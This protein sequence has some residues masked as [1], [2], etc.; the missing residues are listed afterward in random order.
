MPNFGEEKQAKL[1]N[2]KVLV[3][4]TGGLGS[5]VDLYLAAA[6]V[7]TLG[8]VDPDV[9]DIT[10]LQRQILHSTDDIDRVKVDSAEET[11]K[12]LNPNTKIVKHNERV[13]SSNVLK[14]IEYYDVVVDCTDNFPARFL[15]NDACYISKKP[16]VNGTIY[17]FDGQAITIIPG[18]TACYRCVYP[19]PP[20]ASKNPDTSQLGLIGSV[21]GVIGSILATEVIKVI[22]GIGNPL[23]NRL[24]VFDALNLDFKTYKR[25][26]DEN[27]PVCGN[28]PKI[29]ELIDYEKTNNADL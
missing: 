14:L 2:A 19:E 3:I 29:N 6:G 5:P 20:Q 21:P 9:V 10:N 22:T 11:L 15:I 25:Q 7:G 13:D 18:E 1:K 12:A 27:C 16:L 8:I 26:V 17:Q 24:L 28:N 23:T 4:G